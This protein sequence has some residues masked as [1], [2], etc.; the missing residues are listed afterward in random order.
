MHAYHEFHGLRGGGAAD[1]DS[2]LAITKADAMQAGFGGLGT[3]HIGSR[4]V[5]THVD[6]RPPLAIWRY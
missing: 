6:V 4:I 1:L 5:V 2:S 3:R